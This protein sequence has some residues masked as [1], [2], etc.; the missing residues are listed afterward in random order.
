MRKTSGVR[1]ILAVYAFS[2]GAVVGCAAQSVKSTPPVNLTDKDNGKAVQLRVG[3]TL[4]IQL[5]SNPT[6]GFSWTLPEKP[7]LLAVEKN[8]YVASTAKNGMAGVGGTQAFSFAAK[9]VGSATI[10]LNYRRPWENDPPAKTFTVTITISP[11]PKC[12]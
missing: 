3:Q 7:V 9:D 6:T 4:T 12:D 10:T 5:P 1:L 2:V 11:G 8:E